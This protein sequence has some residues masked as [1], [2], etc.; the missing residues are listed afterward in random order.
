MRTGHH[1]GNAV[2]LYGAEHREQPIECLRSL[3]LVRHLLW[4]RKVPFLVA[5][6]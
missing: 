4:L 1:Q 5:N 3:L 6:V 2:I